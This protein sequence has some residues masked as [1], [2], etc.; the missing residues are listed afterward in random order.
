[1]LQLGAEG[2]FA[3][4]RFWRNTRAEGDVEGQLPPL[5]GG[6]RD[7]EAGT[8]RGELGR[9]GEADRRA[10]ALVVLERERRA[11]DRVADPVDGERWRGLGIAK[12]EVVCL[13]RDD[14]REIRRE[15]EIDI[16]RQLRHALVAE[17]EVLGHA[18]ADEALAA[19]RERVRGNPGRRRIAE[20]VRRAEVVDGARGQEQRALAVEQQPAAREHACVV[21]EHALRT[22]THVADVV[23][24][25]ERRAVEDRQ[26]AHHPPSPR[27]SMLQVCPDRRQAMHIRRCGAGEPGELGRSTPCGGAVNHGRVSADHPPFVQYA[28]TSMERD[29]AADAESR[30]MSFLSRKPA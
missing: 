27:Q 26:H 3:R 8:G 12:G 24:D 4:E 18:R 19:D 25:H 22:Y 11:L 2:S 30:D 17:R 9:L 5:M 23:A 10:V 15:L 6:Q 16:E 20:V 7:R 21:G 1:M 28:P 13:D 29:G 14:V